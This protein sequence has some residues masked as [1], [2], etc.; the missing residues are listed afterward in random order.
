[1]TVETFEELFGFLEATLADAEVREPRE[2]AAAQRAVPEGPQSHG[3]GE[4]GVGF[5]P[6]PGGG[7]HAAVVGAAERRHRG[8]VAPRR[9]RLADPDPLIGAGDV[10][11]ALAGR[12]EL[13][14]DLLQHAEVVDVAARDRRERLV[15]ER[16]PLLGLVGVHEAGAEVGERDEF[17]ITVAAPSTELERPLESHVLLRAVAFEHAGVERHPSGFDRFGVVAEQ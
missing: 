11:G 2:C 16:H 9:D 10:L 14:E 13:A 3:V 5:G 12:E 7:E 6:A 1:M 8:K 4:R 15:E 17:E